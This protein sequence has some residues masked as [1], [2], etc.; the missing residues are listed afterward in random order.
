MLFFDGITCFLQLLA[1]HFAGM[2]DVLGDL[3]SSEASKRVGVPVAIG[4]STLTCHKVHMI[5][6]NWVWLILVSW[7]PEFATHRPQTKL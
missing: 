4:P 7:V 3:A 1:G 2:D 5:G 6:L